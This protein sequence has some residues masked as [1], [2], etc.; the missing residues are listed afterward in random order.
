MAPAA[1]LALVLVAALGGGVAA[2]KAAPNI[3]LIV[4]LWLFRRGAA[5]SVLW[6][7]PSRTQ[8]ALPALPCAAALLL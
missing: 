1:A 3:L 2:A 6:P 5:D 7:R 4:S 8:A